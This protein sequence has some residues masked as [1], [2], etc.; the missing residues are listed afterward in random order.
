MSYKNL[1][2]EKI[3]TIDKIIDITQKHNFKCYKNFLDI[4]EEYFFLNANDQNNESAFLDLFYRLNSELLTFEK[5]YLFL[6]FNINYYKKCRLFCNIIAGNGGDDA[7]DICYNMF[8]LYKLYFNHLGCLKSFNQEKL[9]LEI[10]D[11]FVFCR[12]LIVDNLVYKIIRIS[13][14]CNKKQTSF[15]K[16]HFYEVC[17]VEACTEL[18]D[19]EIIVN[20][21][22]SSGAGGQHVNTTESKVKITHKDTGIS[23]VC[24]ETRSQ[25]QNRELAMQYLK[26]KINNMHKLKKMIEKR[27]NYTNLFKISWFNFDCIINL[28]KENFIKNN[29]LNLK[30]KIKNFEDIN[31][32]KL[33]NQSFYI[34]ICSFK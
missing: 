15:I 18:K 13:P 29:R 25:I 12:M 8:N 3:A 23:V 11:V 24:A 20:T 30:L 31:L 34:I 6:N 4:R 33:H 16:V 32:Y 17:S 5:E 14:F 26:E 7:W 2:E 9:T 27:E 19:H 28:H 1:L 21:C 22:K 10:K